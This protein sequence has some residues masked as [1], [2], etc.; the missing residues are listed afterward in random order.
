MPNDR[1]E[2]I[3]ILMILRCLLFN[4]AIYASTDGLAVSKTGNGS[5]DSFDSRM[6]L[7]AMESHLCIMFLPCLSGNDLGNWFLHAGTNKSLVEDLSSHKI[8]VDELFELD[9]NDMQN[10]LRFSVDDLQNVVRYAT[11]LCSHPPSKL[12]GNS[13][14][15][16]LDD[17]GVEVCIESCT[18]K[19]SSFVCS[20]RE[21]LLPCILTKSRAREIQL[22]QDSPKGS[23]T[24]GAYK[25][26]QPAGLAPRPIG[27]PAEPPRLGPADGPTSRGPGAP[28][29]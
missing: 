29:E 24:I 13:T 4:I 8:S 5:V 20:Y 10:T 17:G 12:E 21:P 18:N 7:D 16:R 25:P 19:D 9:W 6:C 11:K 14:L 15:V 2:K 3:V 22:T 26:D 28:G 1:K 23:S 27:A